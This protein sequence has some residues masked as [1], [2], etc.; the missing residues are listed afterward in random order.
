[1]ELAVSGRPPLF[2]LSALLAVAFF[3][4]WCFF[5][6]HLAGPVKPGIYEMFKLGLGTLKSGSFL[7]RA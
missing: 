6:G 4:A 3:I 1:M 5:L 7:H 2:L